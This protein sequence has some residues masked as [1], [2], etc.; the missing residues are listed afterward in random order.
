LFVFIAAWSLE[1]MKTSYLAK[2]RMETELKPSDSVLL[3][4]N[5]YF[6]GTYSVA[7][8]ARFFADSAAEYSGR[9]MKTARAVVC[10]S[11]SIARHAAMK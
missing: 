5:H 3:A 6:K 2:T 7:N 11:I 10:N 8:V 1:R 4:T 9:T